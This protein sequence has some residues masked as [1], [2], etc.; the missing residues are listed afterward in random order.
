MVRGVDM[1]PR[2]DGLFDFW[3]RF[4][5]FRNLL[6]KFFSELLFMGARKRA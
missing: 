3:W 4:E 2:S 5:V 1:R 6:K